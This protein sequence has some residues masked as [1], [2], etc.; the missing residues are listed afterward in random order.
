M[1]AGPLPS[2]FTASV[3]AIVTAVYGSEATNCLLEDPV[4]FMRA[5]GSKD[6]L[7]DALEA[8]CESVWAPRT[9]TGTRHSRHTRVMGHYCGTGHPSLSP[10]L[11]AIRCCAGE[12]DT[13]VLAQARTGSLALGSTLDDRFPPQSPHHSFCPCCLLPVP[14]TLAHHLLGQCTTTSI[15]SDA[16]RSEIFSYMIDK[17]P[18]WADDFE[19]AE[20]D[21]EKAALLLAAADEDF[22]HI[23]D[24]VHVTGI[25]TR[26]LS[27]IIALHPLCRKQQTG[28]HYSS[29]RYCD[30]PYLDGPFT[31]AEDRALEVR[32]D[33]EDVSLRAACPHRKL[34]D[35]KAQLAQ[36]GRVVQVEP[37]TAPARAERHAIRSTPARQRGTGH[38]RCARNRVSTL[39]YA[40]VC[41]A[42]ADDNDDEDGDL[43]VRTSRWGQRR[44]K[45]Q[46]RREGAI[47]GIP[48]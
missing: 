43:L 28:I 35:V 45:L 22:D 19:E 8:V 21:E 14:D 39:S 48:I 38:R 25:V 42:S 32:P 44:C 16:Y 30:R 40:E 47:V 37:G 26:W 2:N 41:I 36:R 27:G 46:V 20:E 7:Q 1:A 4:A 5:P 18:E 31:P 24:T 9:G 12:H 23:S 11:N 33:D 34:H 15:M 10:H 17:V 13:F 3:L 6:L 29:L